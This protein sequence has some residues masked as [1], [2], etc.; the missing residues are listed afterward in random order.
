M[1]MKVV[2]FIVTLSTFFLTQI[3][4]RP[5]HLFWLILFP[6]LF[7]VITTIEN[8]RGK[9][10]VLND[11]PNSVRVFFA[12]LSGL[13]P[14]FPLSIF[15]LAIAFF[16][17]DELQR[18]LL[19]WKGVIVLSGI[20]GTG[21]TTHEENIYNYLVGK[22]ILCERVRFS[23]YI[24]IPKLHSLAKLVLR[25]TPT[26]RLPMQNS[27]LPPKIPEMKIGVAHRIARI[28]L[29]TFRFYL[30]FFDNILLFVVK[31]IPAVIQKKWIICDRFI[32][33]NCIK[34]KILGYNVTGLN[35]L[36]VLLKPWRCLIFDVP[37]SVAVHR[38]A[39]REDHIQYTAE[40][41]DVE[42]K[43]FRG[44]AHRFGYPIISTNQDLKKTWISIYK[45]VLKWT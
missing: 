6:G 43:F 14:F 39:Q 20:D 40:Q 9:P 36:S 42:R 44:L 38:V 21:K 19:A 34:H 16:L 4:T 5:L 30:A 7:T 31:V 41:Y 29:N 1:K 35:I 32:W 17:N 25:R 12:T 24:L 27:P 3:S 10:H 28:S 26:P 18:R 23:R 11:L 37:T 22:G 33:D 8:I 2:V 45:E 15:L 13:V